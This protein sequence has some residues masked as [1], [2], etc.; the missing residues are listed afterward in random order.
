[1]KNKI[2]YEKSTGN[3]FEDIGFEDAKERLMKANI[4]AKICQIID[5]KSLKQKEAAEL[6]KI[7]QPKISALYNGRLSGFTLD[8]LFRFLYLLNQDIE[9]KISDSKKIPISN[10]GVKSIQ[11]DQQSL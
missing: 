8:R 6:L 7:D 1:M 3:V 2:D 10:V 11:R 5:A 4:A 9:V